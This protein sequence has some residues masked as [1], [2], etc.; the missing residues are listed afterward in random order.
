MAIYTAYNGKRKVETYRLDDDG[1]KL[2]YEDLI[3]KPDITI[4]KEEFVYGGREHTIPLVT[5]WYEISE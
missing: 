4:I 3:N 5:I 2:L 1:E